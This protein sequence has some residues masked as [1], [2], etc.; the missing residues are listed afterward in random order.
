MRRR[1]T[2]ELFVGCRRPSLLLERVVAQ[3]Q[4]RWPLDRWTAARVRIS[5]I[6]K[7]HPEFTAKQVMRK[8]EPEQ[9]VRA[10]FVQR[11]MR[12]CWRASVRVSAKQRLTG[13]RVYS[14]WCGMS[15]LEQRAQ[16]AGGTHEKAI[17]A[18]APAMSGLR[19]FARCNCNPREGRSPQ[20][21]RSAGFAAVRHAGHA[22]LGRHTDG[23]RKRTGAPVD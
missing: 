7:R 16:C 14:P 1:N 12:Q 4:M 19:A 18:A 11:V 17:N 20:R 9:A 2:F 13:R 3:K 23:Y 22:Y 8:L 21:P 10:G 6:W 15:E 5:A